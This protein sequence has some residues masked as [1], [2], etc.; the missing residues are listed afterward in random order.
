MRYIQ[1]ILGYDTYSKKNRYAYKPYRQFGCKS[2]CKHEIHVPLN[3]LW[4]IRLIIPDI[5]YCRE[6]GYYT[7]SI[8]HRTC[9]CCGHVMAFTLSRNRK[10]Y[11]EK[12][13]RY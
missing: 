1:T 3:Q 8:R 4:R 10:T 13:I 2:F 11:N 9:Y 12:K 7:S 5:I 6:C